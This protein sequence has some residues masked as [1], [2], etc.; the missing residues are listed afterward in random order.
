MVRRCDVCA[1]LRVLCCCSRLGFACSRLSEAR[2]TVAGGA[3]GA[4]P[5]PIGSSNTWARQA[6]SGG[7]AAGAGA[8]G[9]TGDAGGE[10]GGASGGTA[11]AP[12][13]GAGVAAFPG[14]GP[15]TPEEKEE[16]CEYVEAV[17]LAEEEE[18]VR[19]ASQWHRHRSANAAHG[20]LPSALASPVPACP[21][22]TMPCGVGTVS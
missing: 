1:G 21:G 2:R 20:T 15:D 4:V 11:G 17:T 14:A 3:V 10:T 5:G 9:A 19:L 8:D 6:D 12:S 16:R 18:E 22:L 7:E 13:A